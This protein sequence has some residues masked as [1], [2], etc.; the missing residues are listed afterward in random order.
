MNIKKFQK[1]LDEDLIRFIRFK[2]RNGYCI[3]HY[4]FEIH[5][6]SK[7]SPNEINR[8]FKDKKNLLLEYLNKNQIENYL[9]AVPKK[10]KLWTF[11]YFFGKKPRKNNL[12]NRF[13]LN[14]DEYWKIVRQ[15]WNLHSRELPMNKGFWWKILSS[16][17]TM[18]QE[19]MNE[20]ER[21][22]FEKLPEK[23]TV[24]QGYVSSKSYP[25]DRIRFS[26]RTE[27]GYS[28]SL[29]E[30][31]G[32]KY[33]NKYKKYNRIEDGRIYES[34]LISKVVNKKDVFA[35]INDKNEKEIIILFFPFEYF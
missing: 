4:Q 8:L 20:K 17:R 23:F 32:L 11:E 6:I 15:L 16:D 22:F 2:G 31:I 7:Y 24:F 28:Y 30:N 9:L 19:F 3:F 26:A 35:F 29:L 1:E 18:K 27:I 34:T 14:D 12:P 5:N 33:V 13:Y 21:I 25:V 10:Y